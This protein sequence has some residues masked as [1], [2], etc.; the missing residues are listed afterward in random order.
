MEPQVDPW[1][2]VVPLQTADSRLPYLCHSPV[3]QML[4]YGLGVSAD[5]VCV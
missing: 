1:V 2:G 5:C 4:G 3:E